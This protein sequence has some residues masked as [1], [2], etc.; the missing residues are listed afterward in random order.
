MNRKETSQAVPWLRQLVAGLSPRRP[1]SVQVG[2]VVDKVVLEQDLLEFFSF[3]PSRSFHCGSPY[4][5]IIGEM[6]NRPVGGRSS[7]TQLS[8][9]RHERHHLRQ[10]SRAISSRYWSRTGLATQWHACLKWHE[11]RFSWHA[12]FSAVPI[13][14]PTNHAILRRIY[15][16]IYIADCIWLSLLPNYAVS[17]YFFFYKIISGEKLS[18]AQAG[19]LQMIPTIYSLSPCNRLNFTITII[20]NYNR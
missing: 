11:R 10:I 12:A 17:E 2:Y 4:S 13:S 18:V 16:Y 3:L 19:F 1:G 5:Y 14:S 6:N 20:Y 8:L 9:H 15:I 7:E